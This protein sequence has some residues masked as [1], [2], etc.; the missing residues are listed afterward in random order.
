MA[1]LPRVAYQILGVDYLHHNAGRLRNAG[2]PR[3]RSRLPR[4]LVADRC[5]HR[6]PW[7]S[8][9]HGALGSPQSP[10]ATP[11]GFRSLFLF[12]A[13]QQ[14]SVS[15]DPSGIAATTTDGGDTRF[16]DS[17]RV[18]AISRSARSQCSSALLSGRPSCSQISYAR[19]AIFSYIS[20]MPSPTVFAQ[21]LCSYF[22]TQEPHRQS[23]I[24]RILCVSSAQ[25]PIRTFPNRTRVFAEQLFVC[26]Q[27]VPKQHLS[28]N[29][30]LRKRPA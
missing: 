27:Y 18:S 20:L 30:P 14:P 19:A 6:H 11:R 1:R 12:A 22:R 8:R 4:L 26:S 29:Q 13:P 21:T 10:G 3:L 23:N 17:S 2:L 16:R 15:T 5:P 28:P 25:T 9:Q 24:S 7:D